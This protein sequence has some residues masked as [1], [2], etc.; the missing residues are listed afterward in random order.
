[1]KILTIPYLENNVE[2][3]LSKKSKISTQIAKQF[4]SIVGK[5]NYSISDIDR[6]K[7]SGAKLYLEIL[8]ARKGIIDNPPDAVIYPRS[9]R[10]VIRILS[11]CKSKKIPVV[12][13]GG[14][15]SVTRALEL[16]KGGISLDLS[17]H[18][19]KVKSLNEKNSTVTVEAGILGPLLEKFLNEK[20]YTCGHFP[21]SFEYSTPG[22]WVAARGAGQASTGYG[23]MEDMLISL[24]MVTT[25][26]VVVTKDYPAASIGPDIDQIILGSEGIFGVITEITMKVRKY[27]PL[28]SS[29]TSFMFKDFESAVTAMR[30]V[31]QGGFGLPHFFRLQDPEETELAFKMSGKTGS[32]ADKFLTLIGYTPMNRSLMHIIV[33]GDK[34][35][36]KFV[37]KKIKKIAKKYSGF[38]TGKSPVKKWLEQRYSSAY[39]RDAFMDQAMMLDTLETAVSWEN[40]LNLW[41]KVRQVVK[42]RTETFCLVHIS[43]AYENGAN[44]YFIFMS[45]MKKGDEILDFTKY[46]KEIIDAIHKNGG[47][48]S[49]HHGIGRMLSP[50]MKSEV[51]ELGLKTLQSLKKNFD[52]SG[53]MN[54]GGMLGL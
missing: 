34:D 15:T 10:E 11:I 16:P 37:L 23:K 40:L 35:Y 36:S 51:G 19:T 13:C 25:E 28:N 20:G 47:S 9:E 32:I 33:D 44:L 21:Q 18:F 43:H 26:G 5:E 7:H 17:K 54:P 42:S 52:P 6:A 30:E 4:I 1:M 53:V 49:H 38:E 31:M 27:N 22:G 8:K 24:R 46:Q 39:L 50:W 41:E 45:P 48:L 3:K 14:R 2:V 12:P 29:L